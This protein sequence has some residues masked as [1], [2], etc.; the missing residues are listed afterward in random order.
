MQAAHNRNEVLLVY[1]PS[2]ATEDK[3]SSS[4]S[5]LS[6]IAE[7]SAETTLTDGSVRLLADTEL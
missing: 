3:D 2:T 4:V 6:I 1:S 7:S 5:A